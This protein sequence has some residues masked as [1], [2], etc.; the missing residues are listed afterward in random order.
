MPLSWT[1]WPLTLDSLRQHSYFIL[2]ELTHVNKPLSCSEAEEQSA[3]CSFR[4]KGHRKWEKKHYESLSLRQNRTEQDL[5]Q[6][7]VL[8]CK[9]LWVWRSSESRVLPR[10]ECASL[11]LLWVHSAPKTRPTSC[12]VTAPAHCSQPI[13]PACTANRPGVEGCSGSKE[14]LNPAESQQHVAQ[15]L[16][17][18]SFNWSN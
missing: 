17:K 4:I 6:D 11:L 5:Q 3:T 1:F 7:P 14:S 18:I 10:C 13:Y 15:C 12:S 8:T 9:Y 2:K 16:D